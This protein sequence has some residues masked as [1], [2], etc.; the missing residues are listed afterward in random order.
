MD[1]VRPSRDG[2]DS[3]AAWRI[4]SGAYLGR[5]SGRLEVLNG[6]ERLNLFYFHE[7]ELFL[8]P[9]HPE[10][11]NALPHLQ[12]GVR[13]A[14]VPA[15]REAV[16][17]AARE[18]R[19]DATAELV[20]SNLPGGAVGPLP[21]VY[22]AM[23]LAVAGCGER[24]L[25]ERLGGRDRRFRSTSSSPALLQ[26]PGLD[27]DM[28]EVLPLLEQRLTL[29]QLTQTVGRNR[30][31]VLRGLAK[32][33]ASGLVEEWAEERP[34]LRGRGDDD[35]LS[36]RVLQNF[37]DRIGS[38]L[39]AEALELDLD[40]HRQRVADLL[41]HQ[42]D[43]DHYQL[44][45][46]DLLAGDDEVY[47]S[48]KRLARLVH[49]S[50]VVALGLQGREEAMRV[51]FEQA[52]EAYLVLAD[53]ARR[54][55]Y[56]TVHGLRR[57]E[58]IQSNQRDEEKRRLALRLYRRAAA[59]IAEMEFSQAVDLLR[60]AVRLDPQ[61]EYLARLG[62][63]LARNPNWYGQAV[64]NL[65]RAVGLAPADAGIRVSLGELLEKMERL[66][67]AATHF[68]AALENMPGHP[69]AEAGLERLRAAGAG[70]SGMRSLFGGRD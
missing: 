19:Q 61:P 24:G 8:H 34:T 57:S 68:R 49:P 46:V 60:E 42:G 15:L 20:E 30:L 33:R 62:V 36:P 53:P 27:P 43:H 31:T 9:D 37:A 65:Q 22:L 25:R 21:A 32:L 56:N 4:V 55:S 41:A 28:A 54:A 50:H 44:L 45:G 52:T 69:R 5:R 39:E 38:D 70:G 29:Q 11:S 67:E 66:E 16:T 7:G 51:L 58:A 17:R 26:L 12:P 23:E 2:G 14:I 64:A 6:S 48:Y 47:T 10:A 35:F 40:K 59:S 3:G 63:A 1:E 18:L 13:P